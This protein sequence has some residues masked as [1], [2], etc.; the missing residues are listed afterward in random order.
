MAV[1]PVDVV[2]GAKLEDPWATTG[3]AGL[4]TANGHRC[5]ATGVEGAVVGVS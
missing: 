2:T 5:R 1:D 3:A 4:I